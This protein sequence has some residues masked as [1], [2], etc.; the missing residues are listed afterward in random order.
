MLITLGAGVAGM[1]YKPGER[2]VG[3]CK[4][5]RRENGVGGGG[6]NGGMGGIGGWDDGDL[7]LAPRTRAGVTSYWGGRGRRGG[8]VGI[9]VVARRNILAISR[10]A[11]AV[12]DP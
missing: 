5:R 8:G 3:G 6:G 9:V 1:G 4:G 7:V 12:G 10:N 2:G 11:L